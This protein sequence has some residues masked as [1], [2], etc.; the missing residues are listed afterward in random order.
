M[1]VADGRGTS[2]D[3][4]SVAQA[5]RGPAV[6]AAVV[7]L[8]TLV[9]ALRDPHV[10]G[11]YGYCPLYAATGWYCPACGCLRATHDLAHGDL[12]SAWSAN[13]VW[14]LTVPV[15]VG[16]WAWWSVRAARGRRGPSLPAWTAWAFFGVVVAFGVLRNLPGLAALAP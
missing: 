7:G 14:V 12:A 5:W 1:S 10:S 8:G 13:P 6:T 11:S 4:A 9:V 3:R 16:L 2:A 15:L